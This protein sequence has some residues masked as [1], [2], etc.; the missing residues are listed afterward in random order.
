MYSFSIQDTHKDFERNMAD[1]VTAFVEQ[2]Q[3]LYPFDLSIFS[4]YFPVPFNL[5]VFCWPTSRL[6]SLILHLE[7]LSGVKL[8]SGQNNLTL[9][10]TQLLNPILI[11]T[12]KCLLLIW[13]GYFA[14][15]DLNST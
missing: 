3:G 10:L 13:R 4:A 2:V 12:R 9:N 11:F 14:L 8:V 6:L 7:L 15:L 5:F 1:L